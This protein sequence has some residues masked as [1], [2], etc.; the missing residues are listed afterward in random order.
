MTTLADLTDAELAD[1]VRALF[2]HDDPAVTPDPAIL[3]QR[4]RLL[5][6]LCD[7]YGAGNTAGG[8]WYVDPSICASTWLGAIADRA[9]D[10][11]GAA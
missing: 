1:H 7:M 11:D 8:D 4:R 9:Y 5:V 6:S 2:D 3:A 10:P